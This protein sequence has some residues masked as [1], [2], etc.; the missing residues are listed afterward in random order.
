MMEHKPEFGRHLNGTLSTIDPGNPGPRAD[1]VNPGANMT[2]VG[3]RPGNI[4]V[5]VNKNGTVIYVGDSDS[6]TVS[7]VPSTGSFRQLDGSHRFDIQLHQSGPDAMTTDFGT[8]CCAKGV[9]YVVNSESK[10]VSVIN[11][12]NDT[13]ETDV[14]VGNDPKDIVVGNVSKDLGYNKVYVAN[15]ENKTVSLINRTTDTKD[16]PVG[17]KP[18]RI[19]YN[20]MWNMIYVLGE[21]TQRVQGSALA[22]FQAIYQNLRANHFHCHL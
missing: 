22:T 10:T 11:M 13:K 1:E 8:P 20:P 18:S 9:V 7:V 12:A 21:G 6:H 16:I 14:H 5:G 17:I 15:S 2:T 4:D 3:S 19:A